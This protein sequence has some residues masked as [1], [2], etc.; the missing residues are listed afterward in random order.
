MI[1]HNILSKITK[2]NFSDNLSSDDRT[3]IYTYLSDNSNLISF[4]KWKIEQSN[5]AS[6]IK[7]ILTD[8]F[9]TYIRRYNFPFKI[10]DS[11]NC[12]ICCICRNLIEKLNA[13]FFE[14]S[15]K[16]LVINDEILKLFSTLKS[17]IFDKSTESFLSSKINTVDYD[18]SKDDV[19]LDFNL[20]TTLKLLHAPFYIGCDSSISDK[21]E[22]ISDYIMKSL[23]KEDDDA[24]CVKKDIT[25]IL[26]CKR[27]SMVEVFDNLKENIAYLNS[28]FSKLVLTDK[29][30]LFID[31]DLKVL[32]ITIGNV[33]YEIKA[34]EDKYNAIKTLIEYSK[35]GIDL[36]TEITKSG[37]KQVIVGEDFPDTLRELLSISELIAIIDKKK[38]EGKFKSF[39]SFNRNPKISIEDTGMDFG[40]SQIDRLNGTSFKNFQNV[41][42]NEARYEK[43]FAKIQKMIN[44]TMKVKPMQSKIIKSSKFFKLWYG[45]IPSMYQMY[46]GD[47]SITENRMR[48]DPTV[49][50]STSGAEYL[51]NMVKLTN[52]VLNEIYELGKRIS[53]TS[54]LQMKLNIVKSYCKNYPVRNTTDPKSIYNSLVSESCYRIA[55]CIFQDIEIYGF[56]VEG[57]VMNKKFPTSNHIITSLFIENSHES[58][59]EQPVNAIFQNPNSLTTFAFPEQVSQFINLYQKALSMVSGSFNPKD[60][61]TI[62]Q[63]IDTNYD[64]YAKS[65]DRQTA[66][67][68]NYKGMDNEISTKNKDIVKTIN[69][70][71]KD[72]IDLIF[73]QKA[74]C[75]QCC[76]SMFVMLDRVMELA[77]RCVAALH[78]AEVEKGDKRYNDAGINGLRINGS[79]AKYNKQL[80]ANRIDPNQQN[81]R[82][83][84]Y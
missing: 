48:G 44:Y 66:D 18:V 80:Q 13:C 82:Q 16:S 43:K 2:E 78:Q 5:V 23:S 31:I 3:S 67:P 39:E 19:D 76:S 58:P 72:S 27:V 21:K 61:E 56:T 10:R 54:E 9:N 20:D 68:S 12:E 15:N 42:P 46:G 30:E 51:L 74:R 29:E 55:K 33:L 71:I 1:I 63:A 83:Y 22:V 40:K 50:L 84:R 6:D 26:T 28:L 77:K 75:I 59:H 35:N 38:K 73:D 24:N 32:L 49:I 11:Y 65:L 37:N 7:Y 79:V 57:I 36:E 62:G 14:S 8:S 70:G 69:K 81:Q 53:T 64:N 25:K 34:S 41:N 52:A 4:F 17:S 47:A 45:R 60:A